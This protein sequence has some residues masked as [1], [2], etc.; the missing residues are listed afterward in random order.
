M[1][2]V[3]YL[4]LM[5]IGV[6]GSALAQEPMAT[7]QTEA[8][9]AFESLKA[10]AEGFIADKA[11]DVRRLELMVAETEARTRKTRKEIAEYDRHLEGQCEILQFVRERLSQSPDGGV[12]LVGN[13]RYPQETVEANVTARCEEIADTAQRRDDKTGEVENWSG[14]IRKQRASLDRV[15]NQLARAKAVLDEQQTRRERAAQELAVSD[16]VQQTCPQGELL[17]ASNTELG[18]ILGDIEVEVGTLEALL[19]MRTSKVDIDLSDIRE[20]RKTQSKEK[21]TEQ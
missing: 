20:V 6:T 7:S 21:G 8:R 19:E 18:R 17:F 3:A 15:K 12:V 10:Q 5:I 14:S 13:R 2:R 4:A 1:F 9:A 16:V 11:K